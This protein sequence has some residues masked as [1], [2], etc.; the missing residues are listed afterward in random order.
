MSSVQTVVFLHGLGEGPNAWD[1]QRG[2]LPAGF[3]AVVVDVFGEQG[4]GTSTEFSLESAARLVL[5]ELDRS[6]I[7]R[8]H[9]CGLSLGA[10]IALQAA[11]DHPERVLSLTLAAGQVKPPRTLMSLQRAVMRML[12]A[13]L[14]EKWGADKETMLAVLRAVGH[15]DFSTRLACISAPTLVLCGSKDR[16]NLPAARTLVRGIHGAELRIIPGAGHQSHIQAPDEFAR[17]F[18][19]FL[20]RAR[21]PGDSGV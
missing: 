19:G 5:Q 21:E 8:A 2:V 9:W 16:A 18:G 6:G 20:S 13:S 14:V 15:T 4:P 10:M 12:P 11:L 3:E 1:A 17:L 7:D